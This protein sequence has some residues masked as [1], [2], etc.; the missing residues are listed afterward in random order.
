MITSSEIVGAALRDPNMVT[1]PA[2]SAP[3]Y[4]KDLVRTLSAEVAK[5]VDIIEITAS[6]P[7][8]EDAAKF[9]NAVVRAYTR[10][11]EANRQVT[12]ADLLKDLNRQLEKHYGDLLVKRKEQMLFE[13]RHPEGLKIYVLEKALLAEKPSSPQVAKVVGIGLVL[14]LVVDADL[15]KPTKQRAFTTHGP[16]KGL[17]DVLTGTS[18]LS[19]VIRPTEV[20]RLEVLEG[21]QSTSTPSE[22]L[23]SPA[24]AATLRQL[25]SQYD[26]ILIDSP[27]VGLVTDAQVLATVSDV[28]LIVLR[29]EESSRLLTQ[30]ARDA[31]LA[32]GARVAGAV[33]NDVPRRSSRYGSYDCYGGYRP[34][35]GS[36]SHETTRPPS[37]TDAG[38]QPGA[39]TL[40]PAKKNSV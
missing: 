7:Y 21:G 38:V 14:A 27:P 33:V 18:S 20:D 23:S 25:K 12:T 39:E 29:A 6:A 11:H 28:T 36:P 10:W 19:E 40:I 26:R 1:L 37:E 4:V 8:P 30:R 2:F 5:K 34:R 3:N 24:L 9:V 16:S 31:L 35:S 17:V 15:R 22:L 13:Q 32:V